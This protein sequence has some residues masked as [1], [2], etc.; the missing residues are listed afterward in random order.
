MSIDIRQIPPRLCKIL[1]SHVPA[2]RKAN[3]RHL[4]RLGPNLQRPL[5]RHDPNAPIQFKKA[6]NKEGVNPGHNKSA[7][8]TKTKDEGTN[9]ADNKLPQV[10]AVHLTEH[11]PG[12]IAKQILRWPG[13]PHIN[14]GK[15]GLR[16]F[17]VRV[18]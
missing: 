9:A 5:R 2:R 8:L 12:P 1:E 18:R 11:E 15:D 17:K 4:F 3:V 6:A 13:R 16:G 14:N 10:T 7:S